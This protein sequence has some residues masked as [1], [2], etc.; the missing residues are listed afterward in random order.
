MPASADFGIHI[1]QKA[2]TAETTETPA[3]TKTPTTTPSPALTSTPTLT[4]TPSL[5]P[6]VILPPEPRSVEFTAEDGQKL[7]GTY[8]P[9]GDPT[10]P[11]LVLMH[12][13]QGDQDSWTA[14]AG[15]VQDRGLQP[16]GQGNKPWKRADWFPDFPEDLEIAV[17]TFNFRG[18]AGGCQGFPAAEWL[19]D[20]RAAVKTASGLQGADPDRILTAGASIGADGAVDACSWWNQEG[21]GKCLG[22][23]A[24]SPGSFLTVPYDQAA[25]SILEGESEG[26]VYCLF[27]RRDDAAWETCQSYP[28]AQNID[29]G[30]VDKHGMELIAPELE[31]EPLIQ[32]I[33]FLQTAL[34]AE[35]GI[36]GS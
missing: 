10:A 36:N 23:F 12:W 2:P 32:M 19:L 33:E 6:T 25:Q 20:A 1:L 7:T 9:A 13:A 24:L 8:Y 31:H 22:A 18:C 3:D 34:D 26:L 35:S 4:L 11:V 21:P 30:Y 15:W 17:F 5:T 28:E 14:V 16:G 27:A 29:Y